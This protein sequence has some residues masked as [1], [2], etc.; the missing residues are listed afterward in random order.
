MS[1]TRSRGMLTALVMVFATLLVTGLIS[2]LNVRRLYQHD[3]LVDHTHEV[4]SELRNLNAIVADAESGMRGFLVTAD[5]SFLKSHETATIA[6]PDAVNRLKKLT[7]DNP[8]QQA[9]MDQLSR[10]I[11]RR[12]EHLSTTIRAMR[13][14]GADAGRAT[15]I[16]GEGRAA[17]NTIRDLTRQM[18]R[19][20]SQLLTERQGE[21]TVSYWTA[22]VTSIITAIIG[23]LLASIGFMLTSR[24]LVAREQRVRDLA[25]INERL[26]ERVRE[27]T[28]AISVANDALR[29]QVAERERAEKTVRLVAHELERSNRELSQFAAVASHDLQEPLR[30]IQTF[31]DRL[32][33]LCHAQLDDQG[34][35]YLDRMLVS[36]ARMRALIDGLLEYSRVSSRHQPLAAVDLGTIAREVAGDLEIRLHQAHGQ[37]EVGD[38]PTIQADPLQ[39][40]QLLQNLIGNALKFQRAGVAPHVRVSAQLVAGNLPSNVGPESN[41]WCELTVEDNGVGFDPAYAPRVFELFQRLHRRDEFEGT[42]MGLAICKKIVERHGGTIAANSTPG[43]GSRFVVAFPVAAASPAEGETP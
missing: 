2:Y 32:L 18:E 19:E 38:L 41:S 40:R 16:S 27:R 39:M 42:G 4:M 21:S 12:M 17:M 15:V 34:R 7:R 11:A 26:E 43:Q 36:A 10:Q 8:R 22:I 25:E 1:S 5:P 24:D 29:E 35:E 37:V 14:Q 30:K 28:E 33:S 31:G 23:L 9:T 3:R 20:E 13:E 6:V